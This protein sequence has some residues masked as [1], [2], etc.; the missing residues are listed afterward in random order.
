MSTVRLLASALAAFWLGLMT[1]MP[2]DRVAHAQSYEAHLPDDLA[3]HPALC[4]RVPCTEVFPGA[5]AFSAR[6]GQPPYVE[7]YGEADPS[8]RASA[9][10]WAM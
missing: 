6:M 3:T 8:S 2:V 5:Q 4:E 1:L 9:G 7:A 10:C